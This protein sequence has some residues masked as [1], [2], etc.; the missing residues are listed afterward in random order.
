MEEKVK[1]YTVE[2]TDGRREIVKAK[3][4]SDARRVALERYKGE[5]SCVWRL[6]IRLDKMPEG[7]IDET[8]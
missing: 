1:Q 6:F 7:E 8:D 2:F 4:P 3:D 5:I